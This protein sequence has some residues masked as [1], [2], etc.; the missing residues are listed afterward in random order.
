MALQY[1][2]AAEFETISITHSKD[3]QKL[4]RDLGADE[5]VADGEAL[6]AAGGADVILV[7]D[8]SFD[9]PATKVGDSQFSQST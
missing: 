7:T 8:N 9:A 5:V 3:K 4:V 1:S 2:K 6:Q